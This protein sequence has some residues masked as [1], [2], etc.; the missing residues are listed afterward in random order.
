MAVEAPNISGM[1]DLFK[2]VGSVTNDFF[3]LS[4]V[5]GSFIIAYLTVLQSTKDERQ[6]LLAGG[7][8]AFFT[9]VTWFLAIGS[10]IALTMAVA[11]IV[12]LVYAGIFY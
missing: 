10:P 11:S 6:G 1:A 5:I 7:F 12:L 4:V 8:M 2:F 9:S 3:V